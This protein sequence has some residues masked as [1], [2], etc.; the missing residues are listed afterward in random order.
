MKERLF[1]DL[2]YNFGS[3][4]T[5]TEIEGPF[6]KIKSPTCVVGHFNLKPHT[7]GFRKG[8]RMNDIAFSPI[9]LDKPIIIAV[10]TEILKVPYIGFIRFN[11]HLFKDLASCKMSCDLYESDDFFID[12]R[13]INK[14]SATEPEVNYWSIKKD[15]LRFVYGNV[16]FPGTWHVHDAD[17]LCQ[18]LAGEL[19]TNELCKKA[20]L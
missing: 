3:P 13:I 6:Y 1:M 15:G 16:K 10:Y 11:G 14:Y 19:T 20:Y 9:D 8:L 17:L 2:R 7:L 5:N 4:G 12:C 18:L